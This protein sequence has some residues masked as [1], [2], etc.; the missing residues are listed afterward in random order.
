[1]VG[2]VCCTE[3]LGIS[4]VRDL[5]FGGEFVSWWRGDLLD[6][7]AVINSELCIYLFR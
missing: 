1:V 5:N 7:I 3:W 4:L 2:G 6:W